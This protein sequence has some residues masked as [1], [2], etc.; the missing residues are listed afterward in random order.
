MH[1]QHAGMLFQRHTCTPAAGAAVQPWYA[2]L[3]AM[4]YLLPDEDARDKLTGQGWQV[5]TCPTSIVTVPLHI[6]Q[7]LAHYQPGHG[8]RSMPSCLSQLV[9]ETRLLSGRGPGA[10]Q[11]DMHVARMMS[12]PRLA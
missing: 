12:V 2:A 7:S 6:Q 11:A 5:S 4:R 10:Q 9:F 1:I 8:V 3:D